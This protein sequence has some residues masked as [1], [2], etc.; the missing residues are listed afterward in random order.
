LQRYIV[1]KSLEGS[2]THIKSLRELL[3]SI[4][5]RNFAVAGALFRLLKIVADSVKQNRMSVS[6][7]A[8]T[9]IR[10]L[11]IVVQVMNIAIVFAPLV[12][13]PRQESFQT[14]LNIPGVTGVLAIMI[15]RC[16]DIF[17]RPQ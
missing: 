2:S 4:P 10:I 16:D 14:T 12:L 17:A 9:N 6:R 7:T 15:D 3:T 1:E 11:I 5:K 8:S 13:Y